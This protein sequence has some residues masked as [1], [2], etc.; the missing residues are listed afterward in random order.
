[1]RRSFRSLSSLV[2]GVAAGCGQPVSAPEVS[3]LA[4][5]RQGYQD[6]AGRDARFDGPVGLALE[7]DGS[8]LIADQGNRRI[9][10][11]TSG[12]VV[13]TVAGTGKRGHGDG[14]VTSATLGVLKGI[15]VLPDGSALI[16]DDFR[17]RKLAGGSITTIAG[18]EEGYQDGP[19]AEARFLSINDIDV[20]DQGV[21]Y[22]ADGDRI[23]RLRKLSTN[24]RHSI[25]AIT[26][27]TSRSGIAA[28]AG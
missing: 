7:K 1:M 2:I 25:R 18:E 4:G 15:A 14:P 12:G 5:G 11:V 9:R 8:L 21:A 13:T 10:R 3:I 27:A 23:R 28:R 26:V 20:D 6:G 19:S 22:I 17:I 24:L 16:V